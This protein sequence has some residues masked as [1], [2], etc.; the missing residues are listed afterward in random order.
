MC[1]VRNWHSYSTHVHRWWMVLNWV[2]VYVEEVSIDCVCIYSCIRCQS[3]K[4]Y[5]V[6]T[7]AKLLF[8]GRLKK[9]AYCKR[10]E[11]GDKTH[12]QTTLASKIHRLCLVSMFTALHTVCSTVH[13]MPDCSMCSLNLLLV[14]NLKLILLLLTNRGPNHTKSQ[15]L[16]INLR[17]LVMN[18]GGTRERV[19]AVL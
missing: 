5:A 4:T 13:R 3:A 9:P 6:M 11:Y 19:L 2:Y 8:I 10:Q 17:V 16:L 14:L 15:G 18:S 12:E 7:N 1:S